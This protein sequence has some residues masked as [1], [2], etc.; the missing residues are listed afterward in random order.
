MM[1]LDLHGHRFIYILSLGKLKYELSKRQKHALAKKEKRVCSYTQQQESAVT[2]QPE[3]GEKV[4]DGRI[5]SCPGTGCEKIL[6]LCI[7]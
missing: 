5:I 1:D 6:V 3:E 7:I 4:I 2:R